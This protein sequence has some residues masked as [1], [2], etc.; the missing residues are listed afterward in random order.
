M[1][2][3]LQLNDSMPRTEVIKVGDADLFPK[4]RKLIQE[5]R[6]IV[7][8]AMSGIGEQPGQLSCSGGL[9][10]LNQE[11]V[12][13]VPSGVPLVCGENPNFQTIKPLTGAEKV[14]IENWIKLL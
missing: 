11:E 6:N 1:N 12:E 9:L 2:K 14:R 10:F 8:V 4:I 5:G 7:T 13:G 3:V